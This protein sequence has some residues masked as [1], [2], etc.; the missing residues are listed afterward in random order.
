[1]LPNSTSQPEPDILC[2]FVS[3]SLPLKKLATNFKIRRSEACGNM[4]QLSIVKR[5]Q[6]QS[7]STT[8]TSML[9]FPTNLN[10]IGDCRSPKR[11][12]GNP[13]PPAAHSPHLML[14]CATLETMRLIYPS[15]RSLRDKPF[16]S[17]Y[18]K[19]NHPLNLTTPPLPQRL[20][21]SSQANCVNSSSLWWPDSRS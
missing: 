13:S 18:S 14:V 20:L 10:N 3:P 1:M 7:L 8:L 15:K 4:G 17:K 6:A 12:E 9:S 19:P 5:M 11:P 16:V 2:N 21:L